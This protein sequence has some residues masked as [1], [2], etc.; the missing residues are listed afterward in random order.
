MRESR[1]RSEQ[2]VAQ[3]LLP[4]RLHLGVLG[5]EPM[6]A[7][8]EPEPV[9]LLGAREAADELLALE[10]D[11]AATALRKVQRGG[12]AGRTGP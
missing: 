10:N 4:E 2:L 1:G 7:E 6:A 8:I 3:D 5:E 11:H 9:A 12:Q